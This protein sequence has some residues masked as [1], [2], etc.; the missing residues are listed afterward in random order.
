MET[1]GIAATGSNHCR[2][3]Q[4]KQHAEP[5]MTPKQD[6]SEDGRRSCCVVD[7]CGESALAEAGAVARRGRPRKG[8]SG[9]VTERIVAVAT[10]L[11]L[12]RGFAETNMDAVAARAGSSKRTLYA[13]FASKDALFEAVILKFL[14]ERLTE[15]QLTI[16]RDDGLEETLISAGERLLEGAMTPEVIRLHRLMACEGENFPELARTV[17]EQAWTQFRLFVADVLQQASVRYNEPF[18]D[19]EWLATRFFGMMVEPYFR[20]ATLGLQPAEV[21]DEM[22]TDVHRSVQLF[23]KGSRGLSVSV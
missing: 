17:N 16:R 10:E 5:I 19:C 7:G 22:R 14:R 13:R 23:L 2:Q 21:T 12:E 11:F 1:G 6:Q 9:L 18:E 4:L 8:T 15:M 20:R 3:G